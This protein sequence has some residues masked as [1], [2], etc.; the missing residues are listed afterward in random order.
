MVAA[1]NRLDHRTGRARRTVQ[2]RHLAVRDGRLDG[3]NDRR[4]HRLADVHAP[5]DKNT[6][7]ALTGK[8]NDDTF[9]GLAAGECL[10]L[11]ASGTLRD[12]G[13]DWEITYSFA[14]SPNRTGI[15]VGS[16]TSIAKK[17]WEYL[18]VEYGEATSNNRLIKVPVSVH[19]E[20]VYESG[21][22]AGLGI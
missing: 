15:T 17:G 14:A 12:S 20:Q 9:K 1:A 8:V 18:W 22:F 21:D 16:I 4:G 6:L 5:L 13:E 2:Q 7:F 10:F 3:P 11:G 19:V